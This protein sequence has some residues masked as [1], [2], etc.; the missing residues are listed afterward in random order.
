MKRTLC[1]L[2]LLLLALSAC[3][4]VSPPTPE[5]SAI[6][7]TVATTAST[8]TEAATESEPTPE[9][10][11]E[12]KLDGSQSYDDLIAEWRLALNGYKDEH[13]PTVTLLDFSFYGVSGINNPKAYYA[14]Y[15]IDGNG[16]K[17][18]ILRKDR[19]GEDLI[20]YIFTR[21]GGKT[22]NVFGYYDDGE[23]YEV[24]W[25]RHGGN[26][27][28]RNGLIDCYNGD[29]SI[30][31]IADDGCSVTAIARA[32]PYD[33]P[34]QARLGLAK[35]RYYIYDRRVDYDTYVQYLSEQGYTLGST[36]ALASIDW[37][38]IE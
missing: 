31:K 16:T 13:N 28:L 17:E 12:A 7:T 6:T 20:A 33:Y 29:F 3:G 36:H 14:L 25:S 9:A 30:Y 37:I 8:T 38:T 23:P 34:D 26:A 35:W 32:E 11:V 18:L 21:K 22:I 1:T 15:D 10:E 4:K 5:T 19:G 24:P 27:I 2:L